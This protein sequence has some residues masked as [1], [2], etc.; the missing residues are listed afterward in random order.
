MSNKEITSP[1]QQR[2]V[3]LK[4]PTASTEKFSNYTYALS[5]AWLVKHEYDITIQA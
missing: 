1:A 3:L 2:T 5:S 4:V